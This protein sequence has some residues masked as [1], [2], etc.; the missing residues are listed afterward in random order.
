MIYTQVTGTAG[1]LGRPAVLHVGVGF[2]PERGSVRDVRRTVVCV[3]L[4]Q[5]SRLKS[6]SSSFAMVSYRTK[7]YI[8]MLGVTCAN[9]CMGCTS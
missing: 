6:V 1:G 4:V 9:A 7:Q 3:H 2:V 8:A 5:P